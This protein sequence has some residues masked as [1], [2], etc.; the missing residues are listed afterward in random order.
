[1]VT[2]LAV[3]ALPFPLPTGLPP[4]EEHTILA[5]SVLDACSDEPVIVCRGGFTDIAQLDVAAQALVQH[6]DRCLLHIESVRFHYLT[7]LA[8][9]PRFEQ[10]YS[11]SGR[12]A[13]LDQ[14]YRDS[15]EAITKVKWSTG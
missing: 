9:P 11:A 6:T 1:V 2:P 10:V 7:A 3:S 14:S 15:Q 8:P 12:N 4:Q 5:L 13:H